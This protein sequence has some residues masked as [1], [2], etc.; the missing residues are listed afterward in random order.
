MRLV[1]CDSCD[2][3]EEM[4]REFYSIYPTPFKKVQFDS[5]VYEFCSKEC[6]LAYLIKLSEE[7]KNGSNQK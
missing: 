7:M 6:E 5:K 1:K 2:K 3:T 4:A